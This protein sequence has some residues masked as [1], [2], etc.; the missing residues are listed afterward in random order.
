MK[1]RSTMVQTLNSISF[2]A[3]ALVFAAMTGPVSAEEIEYN[4]AELYQLNCANCHGVYGEGDGAVMPDLSVVLLDLR[5]MAQRN[6][7]EFPTQFT[8]KII[9]GRE[10]RAAHGPEGMPVWGAAFSRG[11]GL[12]PQA[13]ARVDAKI[14][15]LTEYLQ[16][17]QVPL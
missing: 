8:F 15:A 12:D 5:Y 14:S 3:L 6:N 1:I 2:S 7:G 16:S 11:E 13:Q 17:I 4:G 9:D 10:I